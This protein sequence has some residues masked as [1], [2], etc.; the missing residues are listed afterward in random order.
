MKTNIAFIDA[1]NLFYGGVKSL[2]WKIDY[3]KL[4]YYLKE[5]YEV[6]KV[7]YYAGIEIYDF[8]YSI[9]EEAPIDLVKLIDFLKEKLSIGSSFMK[10]N[11][12]G[13]TCERSSLCLVL[14]F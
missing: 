12:T 9:L 5:K 3:Q 11:K 1:S 8:S 14:L 13:R 4:L 7:F 2:G 6:S 10:R